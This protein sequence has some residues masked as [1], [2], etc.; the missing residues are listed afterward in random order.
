MGDIVRGT[1]HI[2][3]ICSDA[4]L[5]ASPARYVAGGTSVIGGCIKPCDNGGIDIVA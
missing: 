3:F 2:F 5:N 1:V 4:G